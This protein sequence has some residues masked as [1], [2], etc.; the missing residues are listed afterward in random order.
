MIKNLNI[1][2]FKEALGS[3]G[4]TAQ[5]PLNLVEG[6]I[7]F[8]T[9]LNKPIYYTGLDWVDYGENRIAL[10]EEKVDGVLVSDIIPVD[11]VSTEFIVLDLSTAI[12]FDISVDKDIIF[13]TPINYSNGQSG[14]IILN[15][16]SGE[17]P[18]NI[19][20]DGLWIDIDNMATQLDT[21]LEAQYSIMILKY[22]VSGD[23]F[24]IE[25]VGSTIPHLPLS[26]NDSGDTLSVN[27]TDELVI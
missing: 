16:T 8:D 24:F 7:Y 25:E 1:N 4:S 18:F 13:N 10:L 6:S 20:F 26:I 11:L 27:D 9:D 5:R 23:N 2:D 3:S 22:I 17:L 12:N 21:I 15:N 14:T 19:S